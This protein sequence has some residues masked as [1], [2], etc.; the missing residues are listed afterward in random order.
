MRPLSA[1]IFAIAL[2]SA[3]EPPAWA[4]SL[5]RAR[6]RDQGS[7]PQSLDQ[8]RQHLRDQ[9]TRR[10]LSRSPTAS[11]ASHASKLLQARQAPSEATHQSWFERLGS[12]AW[13]VLLGLFIVIPLS[14]ATLWVNER[15]AAQLETLLALGEAEAETI[16][17]KGV[18]LSLYDGTLVHLSS[19]SVK[20]L[21]PLRDARFLSVQ[22][23]IGCIKIRTTVEVY[24]WQEEQKQVTTK[25]K[26]GGG[27]TTIQTYD[28]HKAWCSSYVDSSCFEE[29]HLHQNRHK[30]NKLEPGTQTTVS[31]LVKYGEPYRLQSDLVR[32]LNNFQDAE[33]LVG[34][35]L[36]FQ[37][38]VFTRQDDG[39][40]HYPG[41]RTMSEP[42]IGDCRAKV[43]YVLDGPASILALQLADKSGN[44]TF[45]PYR[46][47]SRGLCARRA[48][49]ELKQRRM[50]AAEKEPD[51]I[52]KE[53]KCLDFGPFCCLCACCNLIT[54]CFATAL[55]PQIYT[56]WPSERT[57]AECFDSERAWAGV[58]QWSV[59][60]LAWL[61]LWIGFNMLFEP[62]SVL[63]DIVPFLGPYLGSGVSW[64][65]G[66][67]T[68]L[69]TMAL[70]SLIVS[71][72]YL[73]YRPLIGVLYLAATFG[74]VLF[75]HALGQYGSA[76]PIPVA[77][78]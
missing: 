20:G 36:Q 69:I 54:F 27:T 78:L 51:D 21:E 46:T 56:V 33:K 41:N 50:A 49:E 73:T 43:E 66:A 52:Y 37:S 61:C 62:L 15:R 39:R 67:F 22:M 45:G 19:E 10:W 11:S 35:T 31:G 64:M 60:L 29:S 25:N 1:A 7:Q 53:D 30:V 8:E 12:A 71:I 65:I 76:Q 63:L 57:K 23:P 59:R 40:Y 5:R 47:V 4:E 6:A 58:K 38:Y 14:V 32:Q 24:Q 13:C 16:R 44:R 26:V 68:L 74:V 55:P 3:T 77:V 42:D 17:T 72:A 48:E 34:S 2:C 28:Y 75:I 70:A 18:D 9:E